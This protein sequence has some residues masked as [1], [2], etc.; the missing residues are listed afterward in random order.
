MDINTFNAFAVNNKGFNIF[1]VNIKSIQ[2]NFNQLL[3]MLNNIIEYIDCIVLFECLLV[4]SV[5][6]LIIYELKL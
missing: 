1:H 5:I 6:N 3:V 2:T 4:S